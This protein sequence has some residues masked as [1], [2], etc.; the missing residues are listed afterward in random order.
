VVGRPG[1][2]LDG[3]PVLEARTRFAG[4]AILAVREPGRE[5]DANPDPHLRLTSGHLIVVLGPDTILNR[6]AD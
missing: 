3:L 6:M 2:R 5:V 1:A 4:V